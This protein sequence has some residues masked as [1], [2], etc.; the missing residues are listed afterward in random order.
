MFF[1]YV[2]VALRNLIRQKTYSAITVIGLGIGLGVF[3]FF[4]TFFYRA[5]NVD[6]FHEKADRIFGVVQVFYS[7]NEGE[8]HSAFIPYPLIPVIKDEIPE[9]ENATR[10]FRPGR[11]VVKQQEN[12][13]F[14]NGILLVDP[15]FFS[16]FTFKILEG[17]PETFLTKPN[18]IVLTK[19]M[20]EKYFG[21]ESPLGH[22]L[23]LKDK[24]DVTVTG[25]VE[26]L[27]KIDALSSIHFEFLVPM[28]LSQ[29]LFGSIDNWTDN[30]QTGFVRLSKGVNPGDLENKLEGIRQ[31]YF[32]KTP[33]SPTRL[34]LFPMLDMNF[35]ASHIQKYCGNTQ[36]AAYN[37]FFMMGLL[38]LIIVSFNYIN[39]STA[40]YTERVKEIGIRKVVGAHR[41]QLIKQFLSES[42]L[43]AVISLPIAV[44]V[45]EFACSW[46]LSR[47]GI[48]FDLSLWT[49][50][51]TI[52]ALITA[53]IMTGFLAGGYPSFLLSSL[54]PAQVLKGRSQF[55]SRR[56]RLRKLL[57]VF[58]FSVS[59]ILI[60]L[61]IVW[62]KQTEYVYQADLGYNRDGVLA[63]PISG[64]AKKN[65][66]LLKGKMENHSDVEA[67]SA[68][69]RLP[70]NWRINRKVTPEGV[71]KEEAWTMQVYGFDYDFVDALDMQIVSG[72]SFAEKFRD[73]NSFV[74]NQ[75]TANRLGWD[76]PIGKEL[77]VGD[78]KGSIIGVIK[79]F[80]FNKL[81]YPIIPS[82]LYLEKDDL[83]Y[84][85]VEVPSMEKVSTVVEYI[86]TN[87]NVIAPNVPFEVLE[88]DDYWHRLY[89]TETNLITELM[90]SVGSIAI[91][92]SCLGLLGLASFS[93][94]KRTKEIGIRKVLGA[95]Q[96]G[97]LVLL[98]SDFLKLVALSNLV[99]FPLAYLFSKNLLEF[100]YTLRITIGADIFIITAFIALLTASIAVIS[101]ALKAARSN[102]I[103]SLRHE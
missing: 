5:H 21:D 51:T 97:I 103:D 25:M 55:G 90:G 99:A 44:F 23:T 33:E 86:K 38:F 3:L 36:I 82:V 92:F 13:F 8:Q 26:N 50:Q 89:F 17:N 63:I 19:S 60:V 37:I 47:V 7:G 40:R 32:P 9:I 12:K 24:T 96:T 57:V 93:V 84:M 22:V 15:N 66:H 78:R 91:F 35:Y 75:L 70:G 42:V 68:S 14:E 72:R 46:F 58:Q 64:E 10:F 74:I 45:Y 11:M 34:Y 53:S 16:F 80:N 98:G 62:Q 52:I 49:S 27:E 65:L 95:S 79:D 71:S 1:N 73:E 100:A 18:S 76:N 87:W 29:S 81:F 101:T 20:A 94:R 85:L 43:M 48:S 39:L 102:P 54:N 67:V 30:N 28:E 59:A 6:T 2:K 88:L 31:R 41:K 77:T 4:F 83:N 61:T 69:S 56:G